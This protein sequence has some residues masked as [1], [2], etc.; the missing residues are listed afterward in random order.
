MDSIEPLE[1]ESKETTSSLFRA[2]P[3]IPMSMYGSTYALNTKRKE[4]RGPVTLRHA[5]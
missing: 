3:P 1:A 5:I 4:A 2:G